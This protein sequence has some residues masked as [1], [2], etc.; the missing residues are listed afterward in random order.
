VA[1]AR[2]SKRSRRPQRV[3]RSWCNLIG[4][5]YVGQLVLG[6]RAEAKAGQARRV[7]PSRCQKRGSPDGLVAADPQ[8]KVA[9]VFI[10][11]DMGTRI[12]AR[13]VGD[14]NYI[15]LGE[16]LDA[17]SSCAGTGSRSAS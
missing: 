9:S 13:Q 7:P 12:R 6:I 14:A 4:P 16:S 5:G 8:R 15:Q 17:A 11:T 1:A 3:A 2:P 10:S